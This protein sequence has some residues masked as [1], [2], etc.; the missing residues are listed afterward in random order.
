ME[1]KYHSRLI[2]ATLCILDLLLMYT[3]FFILEKLGFTTGLQ[4]DHQ[5]SLFLIFSFSWIATG[6]LVEIYHISKYSLMRSVSINLLS[7]VLIH[8]G[9]MLV[10]VTVFRVYDTVN[11]RAMIALYATV[12]TLM[13]GSRVFYKLIWK[14][15]EFSGFDIRRVVIVGTT[16][17]G[18]AL[19]EFFKTHDPSGYIFKGFFDNYPNFEIVNR[20]LVKG[21]IDD[22]KEYCERE[23][24]DEIYFALPLT[25][26]DLLERLTRFADDQCIYFR[27]APDF[28]EV[29][30]DSH[31]VYL[32]DSIP[33]LTPRKEP[34][35][36]GINAG[37]KR[38][39]DTVFSLCVITFLFPFIVPIIAIA[40][41]LDSPGPIIFKQLRPGKKNKLFECY[42]FRTMY[43][44]DSHEKMATKNDK[45][46][47]K[48][49]A[50]LR[51]TS[52]D[53]LPQFFNVLLGHMSV[54]GPRPNLVSQLEEYSKTIKKYRMRHFVTPGITGYA[55]VNGFRG[56]I[57]EKE[58]MEKRVEY[59]VAY[60]E[61]WSIQLDLQII[62]KTVTNLIKG[63]KQAY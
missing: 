18:K 39:F 52:L 47:T 23:N 2:K 20:K 19:H 42:K 4:S 15:F 7:A 44:N 14:Y 10:L 17:S 9:L 33:V 28:S 32:Y 22:L 13:V 6:L 8:A 58:S 53:E 51:K 11:I 41:K 55:Q 16:R 56:E 50:F 29:V 61:N 24:I 45:R 36:I 38:I 25:H 49:G 37:L 3:G 34:L 48:V 26:K 5:Y 46:I 57:K 59:D 54:V 63:D 31:Y 35:G 1:E 30:R 40:I 43:V 62:L 60:M 27:I 12:S 21:P